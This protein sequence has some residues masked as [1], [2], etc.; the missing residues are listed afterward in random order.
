MRKLLAI[1][2][3]MTMMQQIAVANRTEK[4]A[5][6]QQ[7]S[8]IAIQ[9][10]QRSGIPASIKLAQALLES[11]AGTS[12]LALNANNHFGIKCGGS[13]K[14][15][16]IYRKDDDYRKGRLIKSCFR[17]YPNA[18]SSFIAHTEFLLNQPRYAFLFKLDPTNYKSWARGLKKAGYASDPKYAHRLIEIIESYRLDQFDQGQTSAYAHKPL[19]FSGEVE[20]VDDSKSFQYINDVR[21]VMTVEAMQVEDLALNYGVSSKRLLKYNEQLTSTDQVLYEG[22]IIYLQPKRKNYRGKQKYHKVRD[23]ETMEY[24]AQKYGLKLKELYRKN[25]MELSTQPRVGTRVILRGKVSKNKVPSNRSL[26]KQDRPT[27]TPQKPQA[28][29]PS[30]ED[31]SLRVTSGLN[32]KSDRK[33]IESGQMLHY[34][35]KTGDTLYKLSKKFGIS[36][37]ELKQLNKI[38]GDV[39][40]IGQKLRVS[41]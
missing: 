7:Y 34:T 1:C 13:W 37:D 28:P 26:I 27:S 19:I 16:K 36:V 20:L 22:E 14:G 40:K 8:V 24:V 5:Y 32:P 15:K 12:S 25:R 21:S 4:V 23:G 39:I 6:I 35:V 38:D 9:E 29:K 41:L 33:G 3:F 30:R 10:M 11:N 18:E 17:A 2:L 31:P